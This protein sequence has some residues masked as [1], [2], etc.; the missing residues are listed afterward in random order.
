M[1]QTITVAHSPDADDAFM[2][3][4]FAEEKMN[5][6]PYR[7]EHVLKDIESLNRDALEGKFEVTAISIHAYAHLHDRYALLPCGASMGEDYGPVVIATTPMTR[8]DLAWTSAYLAAKLWLNDFEPVSVDFDAVMDAVRSGDVD[9]GVI[10]HEG[11]LTY[12]D[13]GFHP[14]VDLG[15]WWRELTDGLPLPLGGNAIRRDLGEDEM[16]VIGRHLRDAIQYSLDHREE[17]LDYA[18]QYG[19]DLPREKADRFVGMYVNRTIDYGD[20]GREA[21]RRFLEMGVEAGVIEK[22]VQVE[23]VDLG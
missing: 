15:V 18:M 22:P 13:E 17:A 9:A 5:T 8:E 20:S 4:A 6:E 14:V 21:I 1:T 11:Q 10:I 19:R 7:Y 16:K 2:F 12:A 23:F 3:F